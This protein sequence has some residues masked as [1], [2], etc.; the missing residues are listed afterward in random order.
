MAELCDT[1]L[2]LLFWY[3]DTGIDI[4]HGD[5]DVIVHGKTAY[6]FWIKCE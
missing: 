6:K 5:G 3:H 4:S 1:I 2:S